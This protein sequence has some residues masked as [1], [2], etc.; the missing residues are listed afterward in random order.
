ML[1]VKAF[2]IL[3]MVAWFAAL[4]YLP[5]L[6][7][8]HADA[9]DELSI[10]RF[11]IMERRLYYGIMWP[12]A[13]TT[14]VLGFWLISYQ[15]SYYLHAPW[16]HMKFLFVV[17]LWGYHVACGH[18]LRLFKRNRNPHTNRFYRVMNEVPTLLLIVVVVLVVVKPI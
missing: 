7:V 3:A 1:W 11:K 18:Y 4:F 13:I 12:A 2:P 8:Y 14:S 5:R 16:M 6:F 9:Q 15:P 10:R 17:L